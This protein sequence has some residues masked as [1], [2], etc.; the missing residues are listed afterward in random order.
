MADTLVISSVAELQLDAA[1]WPVF[2]IAA[3][4]IF[5]PFRYSDEEWT[6]LGALTIQQYGDPRT[7]CAPGPGA[8]SGVI[9]QT[10]LPGSRTTG[11]NL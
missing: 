1:A 8:S 3:S 10:R 4:V 11:A 7:G 2:S 9:G 5:Y 6:D